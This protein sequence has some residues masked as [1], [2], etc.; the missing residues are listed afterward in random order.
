MSEP[1]DNDAAELRAVSM[2]LGAARP[3]PAPA[4]RR[5]LRDRL[6]RHGIPAARPER[7][8][9]LVA[10]FGVPGAL[11]LALALLGALGAGP[12]AV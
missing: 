7:L 4:F 1:D 10:G 6:V 3:A 8:G 2:A 5:T 9:L 11:L 12:F